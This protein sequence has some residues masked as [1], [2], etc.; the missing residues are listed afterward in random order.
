MRKGGL[1][2][3]LTTST[4][5]ADEFKEREVDLW[6]IPRRSVRSR[7]LVKSLCVPGSTAG[8]VRRF[9][10]GGPVSF[11]CWR[12]AQC[13]RRAPHCPGGIHLAFCALLCPSTPGMIVLCASVLLL[14]LFLR[15]TFL[16]SH[17]LS[18][19]NLV[20]ASDPLERLHNQLSLLE[21]SFHFCEP[22]PTTFLGF[23]FHPFYSLGFCVA[24][25][26]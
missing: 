23:S 12:R 19:C 22:P 10:L 11:R 16:P 20:S 8:P 1:T 15:L 13:A 26:L 9:A 14:L 25:C 18:T 7:P 6:E 3:S 2:D 5:Q 17:S 21:S 4:F 24:L